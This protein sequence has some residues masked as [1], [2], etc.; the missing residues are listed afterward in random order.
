[1]AFLDDSILIVDENRVEA[2][3][4][5]RGFNHNQLSYPLHTVESA[6]AALDLLRDDQWTPDNPRPN[7]LL[8][9]FPLRDRQGIHLLR[10]LRGDPSFSGICIYVLSRS[11]MEADIIEAHQYHIQGFLMRPSEQGQINDMIT[12]L[13]RMWGMTR[14]PRA[15]CMIPIDDEST[16]SQRI[17]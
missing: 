11:E 2:L 7:I 3:A 8:I 9:S 6:A 12:Q 10:I 5:V 17:I 4:L 13:A 16:R 14:R 15:H 1:M